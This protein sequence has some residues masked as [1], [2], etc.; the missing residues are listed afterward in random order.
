MEKIDKCIIHYSL[1]IKSVVASY[2]IPKLLNKNSQIITIY[3]HRP[4]STD[5]WIVLNRIASGI[6]AKSPVLVRNIT[7]DIAY[8]IKD[9]LNDIE[10]YSRC[11]LK[12]V[13]SKCIITDDFDFDL[14]QESHDYRLEFQKF[15]ITDWY[16][17]PHE[18]EVSQYCT[19]DKNHFDSL[20][21]DGIVNNEMICWIGE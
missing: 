11:G 19:L 9:F 10:C 18:G 12:L 5:E 2:H 14:F 3:D 4:L 17:L 7:Y 13:Q 6:I 8:E 1:F 20:L 16:Y 15:G 21:E